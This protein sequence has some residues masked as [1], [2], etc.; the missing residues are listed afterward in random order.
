MKPN[1]LIY[2]STLSSIRQTAPTA[3]LFSVDDDFMKAQKEYEQTGSFRMPEAPAPTPIDLAASAGEKATTTFTTAGKGDTYAALDQYGKPLDQSGS[4]NKYGDV[5]DAQG[6][7]LQEKTKSSPD[8]L[9]ARQGV[10]QIGQYYADTTDTEYSPIAESNQ[11]RWQQMAAENETQ[12]KYESDIEARMQKYEA[13][14]LR[15]L[16]ERVDRNVGAAQAAYAPGRSGQ[17]YTG[18][19]AGLPQAF[20]EGGAKIIDQAQQQIQINQAKRAEALRRAGEA[21]KQN[22]QALAAEFESEAKEYDRKIEEEKL[23]AEERITNMQTQQQELAQGQLGFALDLGPT[24]VANMDPNTL[25]QLFAD[26]GYDPNIAGSVIYSALKIGAA[27]DEIE[28][29]QAQADYS[30]TI[31]SL[32]SDA[33]QAVENVKFL[34]G[35]LS[36][37]EI[38][39]ETYQNLKAQFGAAASPMSEMDNVNLQLK[40]L[41]LQKEALD[42]AEN[43]GGFAIPKSSNEGLTTQVNPD[44]G[45]SINLPEDYTTTGR[46]S[47]EF[48]NGEGIYCGEF[49]N[50]YFG[51]SVMGDLFEE[52]PFNKNIK[53][54]LPGMA[55]VIDTLQP[56]G[57]TGIVL[58]NYGNGM[59]KVMDFNKDGK[60]GKMSVYDMSVQDVFDKGGGFMLNPNAVKQKKT[61]EDQTLLT[62]TQ[63]QKLLKLGYSANKNTT[64]DSLDPVQKLVVDNDVQSDKG[65]NAIFDGMLDNFTASTDGTIEDARALADVLSQIGFY[66][67]EIK[68]FFKELRKDYDLEFEYKDGEVLPYEGWF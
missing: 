42:I 51:T 52:K 19:R 2:A 1:R 10:N 47:K 55:F 67:D 32:Q 58:K 48:A 29:Q 25:G 24:A 16:A 4:V 44:G 15:S 31:R 59:M 43:Y 56:F 22:N 68:D 46:H 49:V 53:E 66:D 45:I 21:R 62:Q 34:D 38:T 30:K 3:G 13:T 36:S 64:Y 5:Y 41:E 54:P 6:N 65:Y 63:Q 7:L 50:D 11:E 28:L 37:G 60:S 20:A 18:A 39:Q 35:M 40:N 12:A 14:G 33:Q 9:G 61:D 26:A 8:V 17:A 57:H 23:K 27:K